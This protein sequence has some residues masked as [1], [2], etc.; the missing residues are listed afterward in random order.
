MSLT[1]QHRV[2]LESQS[3]LICVLS[4]LD[5]TRYEQI[6]ALTDSD[7]KYRLN[8]LLNEYKYIFEGAGMKLRMKFASFLNKSLLNQSLLHRSGFPL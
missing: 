7:F 5:P 3:E 2:F 8:S 4:V 1:L 6:Y